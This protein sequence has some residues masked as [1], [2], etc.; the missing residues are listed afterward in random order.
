MVLFSYYLIL[1]QTKKNF[2]KQFNGFY[3]Q[4]D[5]FVL[6][7]REYVKYQKYFIF[8]EILLTIYVE[9]VRIY[10]YVKVILLNY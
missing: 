6:F 3:G 7:W 4:N 10:T 5:C 9:F 1:T 8:I 2:N